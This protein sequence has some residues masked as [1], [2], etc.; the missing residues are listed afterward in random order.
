MPIDI[1]NILYMC[2][3]FY[4]NIINYY[5]QKF[6]TINPENCFSPKIDIKLLLF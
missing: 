5:S 2:S 1:D 6:C 3:P 4:I